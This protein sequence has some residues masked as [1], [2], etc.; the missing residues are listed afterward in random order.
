MMYSARTTYTLTLT[1][2]H[3]WDC[4]LPLSARP[5]VPCSRGTQGMDGSR[6]WMPFPLSM[7]ALCCKDVIASVPRCLCLPVT[8]HAVCVCACDVPRCLSVPV[9]CHAVCLCL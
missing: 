2:A 3:A 5:C 6:P 8:C 4:R 7:H 1:P 9:M